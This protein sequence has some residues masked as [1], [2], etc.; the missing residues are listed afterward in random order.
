ML[1]KSEIAKNKQAAYCETGLYSW[2]AESMDFSVIEAIYCFSLISV[3]FSLDAVKMS[4][5]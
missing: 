3:D 2:R 4:I 5:A 1:P